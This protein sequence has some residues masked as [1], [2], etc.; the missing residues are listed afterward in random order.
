MS[1]VGGAFLK[2]QLLGAHAVVGIDL[3]H[4]ICLGITKVGV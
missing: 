2:L 1:M 3:A 4:F